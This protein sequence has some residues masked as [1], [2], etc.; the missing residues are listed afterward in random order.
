MKTLIRG[1]TV[2]TLDRED[3]VLVGED[4]LVE[5]ERIARVGGRLTEREGPFDRVI[6]A[7]GRLVMPGLVNAHFHSYDRFHRGMWEGL[8]L[9]MWIL[10]VS[11]LFQAPLSDRGA[12]ARSQLCAAEMVLS[13]TTACVDNMHARSMTVES[14]GAEIQGY[15]DVGLRVGA[16]PMI[17][18]RPF[19][20]TMP[21]LDTIMPQAERDGLDRTPPSVNEILG[22]HSR[23]VKDWDRREG[24]VHVMLAPAGPQRCTDELLRAFA[25]ASERERRPIHSHILET[26]VQAV[27]ARELY[28]KSMVAHLR[29]LGFLSSRLTVIHGVWLSREDIAM[30][31]EAGA[32]VAH[33]P[34]CNLKLVSGVAPV[35]RLL[36]AGVNVALGTDN[37]SANDT[38]SLFDSVKF[39]ALLQNLDGPIP[40]AGSLARTA[41]RMATAGGARSIGLE[42]ELGAVEAGRRADLVLL[43]LGPLGWVPLNDPVRQLVY[44][45]NGSSVRTVLVNG[46]VVVDEGRLTTIDLR[47]LREEAIELARKFMADNQSMREQAERVRPYLE[48]MHRRAV[49]Q[50]LGFSAFPPPRFGA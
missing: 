6:D 28:G 4:V 18:N 30:L 26:K 50:D 21:Y 47:A 32:T 23:L 11:P 43:D 1:G 39:A 15:V 36:E 34:I 2:L 16:A 41:L 12:T 7:S 49:A 10:C 3:H 5:D 19:T 45:E 14:L 38:S 25:S 9:E 31:A 8:P 42:N 37:P 48:E 17:W 35:P 29:D 13:G 24:R 27:T 20:R 33:N 22:F 40:K 46:R 44:C